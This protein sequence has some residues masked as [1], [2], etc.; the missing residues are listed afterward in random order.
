MHYLVIG[1]QKS[2]KNN[3]HGNTERKDKKAISKSNL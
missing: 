3:N 1:T 2:I